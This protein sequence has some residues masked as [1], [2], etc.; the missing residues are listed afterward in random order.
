MLYLLKVLQPKL[1]SG[2]AL[3]PFGVDV[4]GPGQRQEGSPWAGPQNHT[5]EPLEL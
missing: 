2:G 4:S 3:I 5:D 1:L